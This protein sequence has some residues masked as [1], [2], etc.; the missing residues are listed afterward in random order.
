M[1]EDLDGVG[2]VEEVEEG[3]R[4]EGVF[5][6]ESEVLRNAT[7]G[8]RSPDHSR[9]HSWTDNF[10]AGQDNA[11]ELPPSSSP[12]DST[13]LDSS[14][15]SPESDSTPPSSVAESPPFHNQ[16]KAHS[17]TTTSLPLS[18]MPQTHNPV[19][20]S[21]S[22]EGSVATHKLA[23]RSSTSQPGLWSKI[24]SATNS[25][26]PPSH[27]GLSAKDNDARKGKDEADNGGSSLLSKSATYLKLPSSRSSPTIPS[28]HPTILGESASSL[29]TNYL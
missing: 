12:P 14:R 6:M 16:P 3:D 20:V 5:D 26:R 4:P 18:A 17:A 2:A 7:E 15:S 24:K 13:A 27:N 1:L 11:S 23:L 29:R 10:D 19:S 21:V 25:R 22:P 8:S 28:N 9:N